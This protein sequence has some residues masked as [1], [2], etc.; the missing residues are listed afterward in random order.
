MKHIEILDQAAQRIYC[1][2]IGATPT[3]GT[4][5]LAS[6]EAGNDAPDFAEVI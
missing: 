4:A 2:E 1:K 6:L 5:Y 3:F